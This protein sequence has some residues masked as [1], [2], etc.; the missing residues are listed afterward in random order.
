MEIKFLKKISDIEKQEWDLVVNSDYPFLKYN[1]LKILE[2]SKC[3]S[4][5]TGWSPFHIVVKDKQI[6]IAVMP[7]YIKTDSQGEFIFD[8]SW[9]DAYYRNGLNY[10]PKLVSSIP[11]TPASGPRLS[12]SS[13]NKRKEVTEAINQAIEDISRELDLSSMHILLPELSELGEFVHAGFSLR[14]SY[15]FHWFNNGYK[16]FDDF[17]CDLTSRQRKNIKKERQ[18][19]VAQG[20]KIERVRGEDISEKMIISFFNFYQVTYLKRGMSGYLNLEFFREVIKLMPESILMVTAKDLNGN[21]VA[22]ALN[23]YDSHKLY[24]R[25]WG[26]LAEYDSLHFEACYYQGIEFCIEN[27]LLRF[28]PGVQGEHKIKRGFL[29]IETYSAH[30]I[31]DLRF[32]E[33]IGDFLQKETINIKK[34]NQ[35]CMALLPFKKDVIKKIYEQNTEVK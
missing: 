33:A 1:F 31:K 17:L 9:A 27:N 16:I 23:F 8:W 30:W 15:S 4:E 19:I 5:E 28:D 25:Y 24:G 10:Y 18:K 3:V 20:I 32:K 21:Y 22:A 6:V 11:F 12:I 13:G 7:L 35:Q 2:T 26:C 29:P 34:Y 14:T